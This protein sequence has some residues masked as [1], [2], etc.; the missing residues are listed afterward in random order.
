MC[1]F[2]SVL[3]DGV[4]QLSLWDFLKVDMTNSVSAR[5]MYLPLMI[6]HYRDQ[7]IVSM[8]IPIRE[9]CVSQQDNASCSGGVTRATA[10]V[11]INKPDQA[12]CSK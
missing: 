5:Q 11:H 10:H 4:E 3:V 6:I 7:V 2:V 8:I 12:M 1:S 9:H